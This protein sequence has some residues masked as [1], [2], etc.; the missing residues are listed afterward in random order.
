MRISRSN[1]LSLLVGGAAA[2]GLATAV[3]A[4]EPSAVGLWQKTED[5]KPV[6]WV[7]IV[8]HNGV[9]EGAFAKM[10]PKP[11]EKTDHVCD[12]CEDDRK[13]KPVLGLSFIRDMKKKAA[14]EYEDG[15][16]L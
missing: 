11:G 10:F 5:G 4:A 1:F 6:V 16:I 13:D 12:K 9:L 15:N 7:L 2:L 8:D 3:A 14:L